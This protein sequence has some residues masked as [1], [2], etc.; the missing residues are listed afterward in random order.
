MKKNILDNNTN[1]F[2]VPDGYFDDLRERVMN[3]VRAEDNHPATD[4]RR[5]VAPNHY[6]TPLVAA[7]CLLLL[8]VAATLYIRYTPQKETVAETTVDEDFY[9][10]LYASDRATLMAESLN[11]ALP[12]NSPAAGEEDAEEDEAIIRFLE[13]DNINVATIVNSLNLDSE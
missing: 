10:W 3:R 9:R 2:T 1:P 7:A 11:I 8:F 12:D 5:I 4:R 13:Q 6:L